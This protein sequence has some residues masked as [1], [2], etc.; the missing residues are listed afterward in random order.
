MFYKGGV[1]FQS[2][3]NH[4]QSLICRNYNEQAHLIEAYHAIDSTKCPKFLTYDKRFLASELTISTRNLLW[5]ECQDP[6]ADCRS[7]QNTNFVN[8]TETIHSWQLDVTLSQLSILIH[9]GTIAQWTKVLVHEFGDIELESSIPGL[10][11]VYLNSVETE[12]ATTE[13]Y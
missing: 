6:A 7:P 4:Q 1:W 8:F 11:S 9:H 13:Q 5:V 3:S 12:W 2:V 10:G